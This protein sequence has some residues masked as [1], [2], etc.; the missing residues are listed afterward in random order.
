MWLCFFFLTMQGL[1]RD[2]QFRIQ[3]LPIKARAST[4][5]YW[6]W[7]WASFRRQFLYS[8]LFIFS[9]ID[10]VEI[11]WSRLSSVW[12]IDNCLLCDWTFTFVLLL[13]DWESLIMYCYF[14]FGMNCVHRCFHEHLSWASSFLESYQTLNLSL[15][16]THLF[17]SII[18]LP[19]LFLSPSIW[20]TSKPL[21]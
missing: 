19:F 14:C 4:S 1:C 5:N 2:S 11:I 7:I 6:L 16:G 3:R 13:C 17:L 20:C 10:L 18:F 15:K 21:G 8:C 9:N 12:S